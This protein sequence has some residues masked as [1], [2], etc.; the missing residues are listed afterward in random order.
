[1]SLAFRL[2]SPEHQKFSFSA[3]YTT[4]TLTSVQ[5]ISTQVFWPQIE[6]VS[7][8]QNSLFIQRKHQTALK[9]SRSVMRLQI[10]LLICSIIAIGVCIEDN[11]SL[12]RNPRLSGHGKGS[13]CVMEYDSCFIS[14][15]AGDKCC[16]Q[17]NGPGNGTGSGTCIVVNSLFILEKGNKQAIVAKAYL[18]CY[19][20]DVRNQKRKSWTGDMEIEVGKKADHSCV[21]TEADGCRLGSKIGDKCCYMDGLKKKTGLCVKTNSLHILTQNGKLVGD[22]TNYVGCFDRKRFSQ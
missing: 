20:N 15:K 4:N 2:C 8:P 10:V 21:N 16:F 5:E 12:R 9:T 3:Q 14:S 7:H 18:G 13:G 6:L 1:M 22:A 17:S 11:E 19:P